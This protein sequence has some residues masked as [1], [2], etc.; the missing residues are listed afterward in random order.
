MAGSCFAVGSILPA[1]FIVLQRFYG[2]PL[3][4]LFNLTQHAGLD[5]NV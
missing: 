4:Q 3:S 5:E 2:G 1:M